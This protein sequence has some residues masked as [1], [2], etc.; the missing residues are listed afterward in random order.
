MQ[1]HFHANQSHF[2]KKSFTLRLALKQRHKGTRKWPIYH[3][4][5]NSHCFPLYPGWHFP[6]FRVSSFVW[7]TWMQETWDGLRC[8]ISKTSASVLPGF[9]NT[10]KL[11]LFSSVWKIPVKHEARVFEMASQSVPNCKLK[12]KKEN[13]R[14][15]QKNAKMT[16]M[17]FCLLL[18]N[19]RTVCDDNVRVFH[20]S[21]FISS[22]H[23]LHSVAFC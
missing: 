3:Y 11:L 10:R 18:L 19:Q 17:W 8:N 15:E 16:S 9:P 7:G 6:L 14:T 23:N 2:H 20:W 21:L 12:K 1:F 13:K 22:S 5:R 4:S